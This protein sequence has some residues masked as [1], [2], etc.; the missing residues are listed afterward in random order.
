M[1]E[2]IDQMPP[3]FQASYQTPKACRP[4]RVNSIAVAEH[5]C[6]PV[7]EPHTPVTQSQEEKDFEERYVRPYSDEVFWKNIPELPWPDDVPES[8]RQKYPKTEAAA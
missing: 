2:L 7:P 3:F 4:Q 5:H 8:E 1:A 6:A